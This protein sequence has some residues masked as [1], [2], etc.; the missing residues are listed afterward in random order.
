MAL[1]NFWNAAV[2]LDLGFSS[3]N[4][5]KLNSKSK[6][7]ITLD[8]LTLLYLAVEKYEGGLE[9][10]MIGGFSWSWLSLVLVVMGADQYILYVSLEKHRTIEKQFVT[11]AE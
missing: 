7:L 11:L 6:L 8:C 10:S 5:Q 3:S 1:I 4:I 9:E 2:R